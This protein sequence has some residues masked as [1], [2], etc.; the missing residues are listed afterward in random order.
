VIVVLLTP[1]ISKYEGLEASLTEERK[2]VLNGIPR[3]PAI[4]ESPRQALA[5]SD[6]GRHSSRQGGDVLVPA[7]NGLSSGNISLLPSQ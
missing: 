5:A 3:I 7:D 2:T 6:P 1:S 4:P